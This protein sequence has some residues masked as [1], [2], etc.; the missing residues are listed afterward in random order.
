MESAIRCAQ[1]IGALDNY[2][3]CIKGCIRIC[4]ADGIPGRGRRLL[5][6]AYDA[7][8]NRVR[9]GEKG[10]LSED[11]E[12]DIISERKKQYSDEHIEDSERL[13]SEDCR[14]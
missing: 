3:D 14:I 8:G 13:R 6:F 10:Y 11:S 4:Y 12:L 9:K 5:S 7:A 2:G 1:R